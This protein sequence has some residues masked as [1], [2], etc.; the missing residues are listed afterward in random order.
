MLELSEHIRIQLERCSDL[1]SL[2]A[3]AVQI[4][5]LAQSHTSTMGDVADAVGYD[6]ALA[7]KLLKIANSPLYG[8]RRKSGNIRQAVMLLGLNSTLMLTLSFS[9]FSSLRQ[10][11]ERGL[12]YNA[13]W[14]RSLLSSTVARLLARLP[15]EVSPEEAFLAAL[16][17]DIGMAVMDR[18]FDQF[19]QQMESEDIRHSTIIE[20]ERNQIDT[21]HAAVGAWLLNQWNFPEHLIEAVSGSHQ[22]V[23]SQELA[24]VSTLTECIALSGIIADGIIAVDRN[25]DSSNNPEFLRLGDDYEELIEEL[26]EEIPVVEGLF[27]MSLL[28]NKYT[29]KVLSEAKNQMLMRGLNFSQELA[30]NRQ[31][32]DRHEQRTQILK[33]ESMQ[34]HLTGLSNRKHF[35]LA[36]EEEFIHARKNSWPLSAVFIDLD[37][38]KAINDKF[39]HT[40]GDRVLKFSAKILGAYT[41]DQDAVFRYGGEEFVILLPGCSSKDAISA[42]TRIVEAIRNN[43]LTIKSE[44]KI[45]ITCSA[46]VAT[47]DSQ[48]VFDNKEL[49]VEAADHAMYAAKQNGGDSVMVYQQSLVK[50]YH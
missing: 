17:Q 4:L 28:D 3:V 35:D 16:L 37:K 39:G 45:S 1:P 10:Q 6:P 2:P 25:Q 31:E 12:D 34:D 27:E 50:N 26:Y 13:Y 40:V 29:D 23:D 47:L 48:H 38:F 18:A 20:F 5:K 42:A 8:Q 9:L 41:R 43:N 46:G 11:E 44:H 14:Q 19:Y 30:S 36:I 21:D 7:T 33:K 24:S 32:M 22:L 49:L 15:E